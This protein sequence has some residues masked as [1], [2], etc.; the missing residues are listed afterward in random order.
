VHHSDART[1]YIVANFH[2]LLVDRIKVYTNMKQLLAPVQDRFASYDS[3]FGRH[4][5]MDHPNGEV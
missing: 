2:M 3:Y 4:S 5:A 1:D